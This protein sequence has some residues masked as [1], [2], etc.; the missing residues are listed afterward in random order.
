MT[1]GGGSHNMGVIFEWDPSINSCIKKFDFD[2]T[3]NG[4]YPSN[5]SL[6]LENGKLYG[7]VSRGGSHDKGIIFEW[8]PSSNHFL[9]LFD[10]NQSNGS[11]P[12]DTLSKY[13]DMEFFAIGPAT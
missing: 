8:D 1:Y 4:Y 2:D 9:K 11:F 10:F 3:V 13:S 12:H 7:M 5:C 6:T